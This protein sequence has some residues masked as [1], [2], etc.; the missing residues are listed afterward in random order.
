MV[1]Y[2]I[3]WEDECLDDLRKI[4]GDL[5]EA[6]DAIAAIDWRLHHD[7]HGQAT[8]E[9]GPETDI[10]LTWLRPHRGYPAVT[11]SYKVENPSPDHY[12]C[13]V[14]RAKPTNVAGMS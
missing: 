14:L 1:D 3:T 10:R 13:V 6:D 8:W 7:P 12:R 4:F 2:G 11:F 5:E 9:L